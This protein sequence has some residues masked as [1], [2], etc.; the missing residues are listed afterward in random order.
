MRKRKRGTLLNS[1]LG[2]PVPVGTRV[3]QQMAPLRERI[4][5][6]FRFPK[7]LQGGASLH[8]ENPQGCPEWVG[9]L[10]VFA[11]RPFIFDPDKRQHILQVQLRIFSSA[12]RSFLSKSYQ[13]VCSL[14][15]HYRAGHCSS[16]ELLHTSNSH[17]LRA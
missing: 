9:L 12:I 13:A 10:L 1:Y 3:G 14:L 4:R 5:L 16:N 8:R 2:R 7:S 15:C 6:H 11:S 17:T